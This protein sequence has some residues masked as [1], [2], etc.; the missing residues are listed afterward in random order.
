MNVSVIFTTNW[1]LE[2]LIWE[3]GPREKPLQQKRELKTLKHY[4][5]LRRK[6]ICHKIYWR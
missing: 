3:R 4:F 2:V 6:P 1:N 5:S